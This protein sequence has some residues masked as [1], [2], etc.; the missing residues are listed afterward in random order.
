MPAA[1]SEQQIQNILLQIDVLV[2]EVQLGEALKHVIYVLL[3][4][5]FDADQHLRLLLVQLALVLDAGNGVLVVQ[6]FLE[7]L[8]QDTGLVWQ[9]YYEVVLVALE[10]HAFLFG[11]VQTR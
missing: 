9:V 1:A 5:A 7:E 10:Y 8:A 2:A 3:A 6:T 4:L 11:L